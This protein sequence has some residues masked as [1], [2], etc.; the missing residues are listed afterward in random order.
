MLNK[1]DKWSKAFFMPLKGT[2][3]FGGE[4]I[5]NIEVSPKHNRLYTFDFNEEYTIP[6]N[7]TGDMIPSHFEFIERL[8]I[9][10]E[11]L[12]KDAGRNN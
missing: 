10:R 5:V 8:I 6:L 9:E 7:Y 4:R 2:D 11:E 1:I 12:F 3:V